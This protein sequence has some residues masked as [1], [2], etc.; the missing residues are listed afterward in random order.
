MWRQTC[1]VPVALV[2]IA[3]FGLR[4]A[5]WAQEATTASAD[6]LL[7]CWRFDSG[8]G[9]VAKDSSGR[10][11]DGRIFDGQWAKGR[12]GTALRYNGETTHVVLPHLPELDGSD[13]MTVEVWVFWEGTGRYPNILTGG[14]WNPGGFLLFVSNHSCLFRMG[15]P[16]AEPWELG[17]SWQETG[18]SLTSSFELGRWTHLAATFKRPSIT[19]YLDGEPVGSASWN[20]AVGQTGDMHLGK[21]ALDQGKTQSHYGLIDEVRIY[22]RA[23]SAEE[24]Q[25]SCAREAPRRQAE[26]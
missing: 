10:G 5:A 25:A 20:H 12:F 26:R 2:L 3:A 17:T 21:W 8:Q 1:L 22:K 19:T 16:G 9:E 23:L 18:A 15:R 11:H 14:A 6:G 7:G 4:P 24:I 13:E